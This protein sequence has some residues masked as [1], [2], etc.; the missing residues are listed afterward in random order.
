M[1]HYYKPKITTNLYLNGSNIFIKP[2]SIT[3]SK[4]TGDSGYTTALSIVLTLAAEYLGSNALATLAVSGPNSRASITTITMVR[5][6]SSLN[7]L[8]S[9]THLFAICLSTQ[10]SKKN[11]TI[12]I[13]ILIV[14]K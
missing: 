13:R 3:I 1:S 12:S 8:P 5:N 2:S 11:H 4:V 10:H 14:M 9:F 6:G 7:I